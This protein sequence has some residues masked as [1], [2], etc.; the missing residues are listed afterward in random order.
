RNYIGSHELQVWCI[1]PFPDNKWVVSASND[2]TVVVWKYRTKEKEYCWPHKGATAVSVSHDGK[3]VVSGGH[4]CALRLWNAESSKQ[5]TGPW[6]LHKERIWSVQW[7]PDGSHIVSCSVDSTL[8]ICKADSGEP[9]FKPLS[10]EQTAV[11]A[12]AYSRMGRV[13]LQG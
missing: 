7:S 4:D 11:H 9:N 12:I 13:L 3:K 1:A 5:L 10:T 6:K 8:I 2:N